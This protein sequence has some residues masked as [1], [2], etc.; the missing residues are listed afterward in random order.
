MFGITG[1]LLYILIF[2][3]QVLQVTISTLRV[4]FMNKNRKSLVLFLTFL[5]TG[6]TL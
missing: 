2:A 1:T 5:N 4:I 3:G 6:C